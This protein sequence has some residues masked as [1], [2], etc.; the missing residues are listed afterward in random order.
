MYIY[1]FSRIILR[2]VPSQVIRCSCLCC[3]AGW[4]RILNLE[5]PGAS[6]LWTQIVDAKIC[7]CM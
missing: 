3:T 2:H 1:S 7:M 5:V 6:N 4:V